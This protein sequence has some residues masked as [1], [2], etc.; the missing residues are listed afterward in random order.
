VI[1]GESLA[2]VLFP[3]NEDLLVNFSPQI[4][5]ASS[6]T[7]L[8]TYPRFSGHK[9]EV[10]KLTIFPLHPLLVWDVALDL[11]DVLHS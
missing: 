10:Q 8:L 1:Q 3:Q 2:Q 9:K 6:H 7:P 5:G 11:L 4:L